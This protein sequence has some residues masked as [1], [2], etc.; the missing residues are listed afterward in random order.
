MTKFEEL[1]K[2]LGEVD[3][4]CTNTFCNT[5]Q[6]HQMSDDYPCSFYAIAQKLIDEGYIK[7]NDIVEYQEETKRL[8]D[9]LQAVLTNAD[10]I[11]DFS[12]SISIHEAYAKGAKDALEKLKDFKTVYDN[13]G[14]GDLKVAVPI[15]E[16][17][18]LLKEYENE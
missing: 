18:K 16:I 15:S 2:L 9:K 14:D 3:E 13:Y 6:Y 11:K 17:N 12:K 7:V 8:K 10:I 5:C 1:V 4:H